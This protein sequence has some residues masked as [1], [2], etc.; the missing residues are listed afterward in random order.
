MPCF[1]TSFQGKLIQTEVTCILLRALNSRMRGKAVRVSCTC[2]VL[3]VL[4]G[5][6]SAVGL[7][8]KTTGVQDAQ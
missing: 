5:L 8:V 7:T 2:I 1:N 4:W 3:V 6:T